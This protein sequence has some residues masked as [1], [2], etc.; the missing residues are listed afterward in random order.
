LEVRASIGTGA[1]AGFT[2][3]YVGWERRFVGRSACEALHVLRGPVDISVKTE[4]QRNARLPDLTLR[5]HFRHIRDL[6]E[7]PF[8]RLGQARRDD[9]RAGAG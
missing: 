6:P 5:R 3:L 7:A 2:F 4:L 8:Q 1:S 9:F